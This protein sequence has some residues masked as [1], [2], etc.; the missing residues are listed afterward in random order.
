MTTD[1]DDEGLRNAALYGGGSRIPLKE[2][3]GNAEAVLGGSL[4]VDGEA[5]ERLNIS[6]ILLYLHSL[7]SAHIRKCR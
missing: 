2:D 3:L 5:M 1:D 4:R 7:F 6:A